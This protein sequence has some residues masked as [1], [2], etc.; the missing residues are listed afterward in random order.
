M[1]LLL[2]DCSVNTDSEY[3]SVSVNEYFPSEPKSAGH[4]TV[5]HQMSASIN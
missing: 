5:I 2:I 3:F 4:V 1:E